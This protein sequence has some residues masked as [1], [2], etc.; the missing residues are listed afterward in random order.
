MSVSSLCVCAAS[1]GPD[2]DSGDAKVS[3]AP[4]TFLAKAEAKS[5][6]LGVASVP[7]AVRI[8]RYTPDPDLKRMQEAL[9]TGGYPGFLAALRKSPVVGAVEVGNRKVPIRWAR[10]TPEG[11][12]RVIS[13][14]TDT[15]IFF[16]GGGGPDA[17]PKSG[18]ELV[19]LQLKIRRGR[20]GSLAAAARVKPG[21]TAACRVCRPADRLVSIA[22]DE[23]G[24]QRSGGLR[25]L[26]V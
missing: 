9:R 18:Y 25:G 6:D 8:E 23:I 10:Q 3:K 12:G 22:R 19:V 26:R 4:E 14:V 21:G 20:R 7:L 11:E 17:K 16:L 1:L 24:V 5:G 13:V 2:S 15:P